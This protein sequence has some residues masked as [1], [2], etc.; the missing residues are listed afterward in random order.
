[1]TEQ[2]S[3]RA[4][5]H[6]HKHTHILQI[7]HLGFK[8]GS[9][10]ARRISHSDC[11]RITSWAVGAVGGS[12]PDPSAALSFRV[13]LHHHVRAPRF[14]RESL[15]SGLADLKSFGVRYGEF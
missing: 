1:M 5:T 12:L 3:A 6:T 4:L 14:W 11:S 8:E 15:Y 2:L 7:L 9:G 10:A 13:L